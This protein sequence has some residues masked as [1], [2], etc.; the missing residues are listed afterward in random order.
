M[1]DHLLS[2][3]SFEN[4]TNSKYMSENTNFMRALVGKLFQGLDRDDINW[5]QESVAFEFLAI[6]CLLNAAI[7]NGWRGKCALLPPKVR[8]DNWCRFPAHSFGRFGRRTRR[9]SIAELMGVLTPRLLL[10]GPS[11]QTLSIYYQG[12]PPRD[13]PSE[14]PD[15]IIVPAKANVHLE[16]N[17]VSLRLEGAEHVWEGTFE[18][19][20]GPYGPIGRH[21]SGT[22]PL[23]SGIIEVSLSK[24][25]QQLNAQVSRYKKIYTAAKYVGFLACEIKGVKFPLVTVTQGLETELALRD[26]IRA[27]KEIFS[28]LLN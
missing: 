10:D 19:L 9:S 13:V 24:R 22:L 15:W 7:A 4:D 12:F 25:S 18:T 14:R 17:S 23:P 26:C 21:E 28:L 6:A 5:D 27:G 1:R 20:L 16:R 3:P 8:I 2:D 11:N